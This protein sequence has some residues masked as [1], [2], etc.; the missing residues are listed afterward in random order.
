MRIAADHRGFVLACVAAIALFAAAYANSLDNGFHFDDRHTVEENLFIRDI[1]NAPRYFTD[2]RTFSS[3]PQNQ[4]YRP[5]FTLSAAADYA[6][7]RGL[8][9]RVFHASQLLLFAI[10]GL[11]LALFYH[12]VLTVAPS[13]GSTRWLALL[14]ATLFCVH[15][16]NTQTGNYISARSELLSAIGLLGGF[17]LYQRVPASR[18]WHLYLLPVVAGALGKN[19]AVTFAPLLLG[20]KLLIEEQLS[21]RDTLSRA[22]R[23]PVLRAIRSSLPA[24]VVLVALFLFMESMSPP[25]QTHGG[26]SRFD[27]LVTQTWVWVRYAWLYFLP[28][29]LSADTDMQLFTTAADWRVLAGLALLTAS[30][31]AAWQASR[32]ARFRP[33]A[34]GILWFW[35][36]LGPTSSIFPLAEVTNDHRTFLPFMG[37]NLAVI[38]ALAVPAGALMRRSVTWRA[39]VLAAAAA[40]LLAHA[41]ATRVRNRVWRN[42]ATLWADVA[43]KSPDNARGLMN[44][45]IA[46]MA[47]GRLAEARDLFLRGQQLR[48]TYAYLDINLGIVSA[49]MGNHPAA[50]QHFQRALA[51]DPLQPAVHRHYAPWLLSQGR[52]PE[53]REHYRRLVD[54]AGGDLAAR[55]WLMALHTVAGD[56]AA[57]RALAG[58]TLQLVSGDAVARA[59]AAGRS[60]IVP[61]GPGAQG[62]FD[63]G[64]EFTRAERHVDAAVAYRHA[65]QLDPRHADALNNLGWTLGKL[66]FYDV[67]VP[68]LERAI[69]VR[70]GYT[71]ARNNLAWVRAEVARRGAP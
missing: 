61:A 31:A 46:L 12:G 3:L 68:F 40:L 22:H 47:Q 44:Y 14:A 51:L 4:V 18:R 64:L 23:A 59:Y 24:F 55:H 27:Y 15:T 10:T 25:Q 29:G 9:R 41:W 16:G 2:A 48:P 60:P 39:G 13:P 28:V 69:A 8:S 52:G 5:V 53:A 57:A 1:G 62:F 66:G 65:V 7:G 50:G 71:L 34:F 26:G 11:L 33:V 21:L 37:L 45:G 70:P 67:A 63:R 20:Y 36:T 54:L 32:S 42:D 49:A 38:G 19:L 58:E 35:I 56:T 43:A 30:L 17:L 6:V